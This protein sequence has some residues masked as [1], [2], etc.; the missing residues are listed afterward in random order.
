MAVKPA[1][2]SF[3]SAFLW[4]REEL[5]IKAQ[6]REAMC[7]RCVLLRAFFCGD[8]DPMAL[9]VLIHAVNNS[10]PY[11]QGCPRPGERSFFFFT[12]LSVAAASAEV[13][14]NTQA[15]AIGTRE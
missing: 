13:Y 2:V 8:S 6:R 5:C 15:L 11:L 4:G 1:S 9:A 12:C 7:D 14:Q 10:R 3:C